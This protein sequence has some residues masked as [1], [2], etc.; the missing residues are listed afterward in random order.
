M[1]TLCISFKYTFYL[2]SLRPPLRTTRNPANLGIISGYAKNQQKRDRRESRSL[3]L[4]LA[5]SAA[6]KV[7]LKIDACELNVLGSASL[8]LVVGLGKISLGVIGL[9]L[10]C[11]DDG[12]EVL[13]RS[14]AA[15]C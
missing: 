1:I 8:E 10:T 15:L 6:G 3:I 5:V 9:A 4:R 12:A 14:V 13:N 7:R 2:F 11:C